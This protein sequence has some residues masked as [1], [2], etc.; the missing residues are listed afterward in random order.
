MRPTSLPASPY[1]HPDQVSM[2][3]RPGSSFS[4]TVSTSV[5]GHRQTASADFSILPSQHVEP[6]Q[7]KSA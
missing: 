7:D 3:P 2:L 1:L 5:P 6:F 4:L